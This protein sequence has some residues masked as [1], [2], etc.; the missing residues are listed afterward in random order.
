MN[1][2]IC[3]FLRRSFS[4]EVM[5]VVGQYEWRSVREKQRGLGWGDLQSSVVCLMEE[6]SEERRGKRA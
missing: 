4:P 5:E 6:E 1:F 2:L 3:I